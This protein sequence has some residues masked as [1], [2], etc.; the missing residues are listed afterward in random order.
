MNIKE[1][2]ELWD[3]LLELARIEHTDDEDMEPIF[4]VRFEGVM[5]TTAEDAENDVKGFAA[6]TKELIEDAK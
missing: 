1:K 5:W 3:A 6:C 2:A 4:T